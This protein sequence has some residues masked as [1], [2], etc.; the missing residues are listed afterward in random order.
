MCARRQ[1]PS[2]THLAILHEY[3]ASA[4]PHN[5]NTMEIDSHIPELDPARIIA[6]P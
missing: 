4:R 3:Y 2:G 1:L 6:C 5:D